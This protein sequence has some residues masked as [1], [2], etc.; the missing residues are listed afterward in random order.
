ME[1]E[2]DLALTDFRRV[3][4][5]K[6]SL[7]EKLKVSFSSFFADSEVAHREA[8][9]RMSWVCLAVAENVLNVV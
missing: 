9:T 4:A 5:E 1:E 8:S 7:R 6:E 3:M 2:R